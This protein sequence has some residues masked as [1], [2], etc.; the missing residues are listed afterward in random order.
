VLGWWARLV[1]LCRVPAGVHFPSD[2]QMGAQ[3]GMR[4]GFA[5]ASILR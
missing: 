2:V 5:A 1:A 4:T 3:L